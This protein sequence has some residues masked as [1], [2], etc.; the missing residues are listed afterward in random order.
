MAARSAS[1]IV[2][3]RKRSDWAPTRPTTQELLP[4]GRDGLDPHRLVEERADKG[5]S[6]TQWGSHA[7]LRP[8]RCI[9]I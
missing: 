7:H 9:Q 5:L 8:W 3:R 4:G 6:D 1:D 2:T